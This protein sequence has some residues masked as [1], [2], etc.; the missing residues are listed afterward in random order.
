[1]QVKEANGNTVRLSIMSA[2]KAIIGPYQV[3]IETKSKDSSGEVSMS[4]YKHEKEIY[5]LFN[6][7]CSGNYNRLLQTNQ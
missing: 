1:M 2:A 4:R 3:M 6:V 5:I 7:W